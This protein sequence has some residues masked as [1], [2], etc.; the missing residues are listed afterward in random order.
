LL[1]ADNSLTPVGKFYDDWYKDFCK[2][3]DEQSV[4][5]STGTINR[6]GDSVLKVSMLLSLARSDSMEITMEDMVEAISNC[7]LLIGNARRTTYGKNGDKQFSIRKTLVIDE[8]LLRS[9][10]TI[11]RTQLL[12]KYWM[13]GNSLEWDAVM[14]NFSDSGMIV[15]ESVGDQILYV[16]PE[17]Q[18][19]QINDFMHGKNVKEE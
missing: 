16:M 12:K 19:K 5:D 2:V 6:F 14:N 18:V 10:H 8:L 13:H 1:N 11:S 15:M 7:E 3:I 4:K 9:N 17:K